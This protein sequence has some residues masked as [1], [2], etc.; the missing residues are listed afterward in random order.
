MKR[1]VTPE[2]KMQMIKIAVE[3][4]NMNARQIS[5]RIGFTPE[6]VKRILTKCNIN[7]RKRREDLL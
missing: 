6:T 1:I 3:N 5:E 2:I 4:P 7:F